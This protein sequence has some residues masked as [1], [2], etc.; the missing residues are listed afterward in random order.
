MNRQY[1]QFDLNSYS[2]H[3][4]FLFFSIYIDG[5]TEKKFP[6][7]LCYNKLM[8]QNGYE[9]KINIKYS[10]TDQNLAMK[11]FALLNFLQDIASKK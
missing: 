7:N 3:P 1:I 5:D 11:P 9:E 10:E 6:N 8:I 4:P 2:F